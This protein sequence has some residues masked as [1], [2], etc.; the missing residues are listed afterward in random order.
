M[1]KVLEAL[2]QVGYK[3]AIKN[4]QPL[5]G[6]KPILV[7]ENGD[8]LTLGTMTP[9]I[10]GTSKYHKISVKAN[11]KAKTL[12]MHQVMME[13]HVGTPAE[14]LESSGPPAGI[15][16]EGWAAFPEKDKTAFRQLLGENAVQIDHIIPISKDASMNAYKLSNLQ[17]MF[18]S[19]NNRKGG[20]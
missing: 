17:Y 8:I 7:N 10:S 20:V 18:A 11:G 9:G 6:N 16:K 4:G 1:K 5:P 12:S 19:D 3:R 2:E 13:T 14:W 15:T